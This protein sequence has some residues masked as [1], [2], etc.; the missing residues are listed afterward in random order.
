[1]PEAEKKRDLFCQ[2]EEWIYKN[3]SHSTS[4][5]FELGSSFLQGKGLLPAELS[6]QPLG[7]S[8]RF[9]FLVWSQ[10]A[11][12]GRGGWGMTQGNLENIRSWMLSPTGVCGTLSALT[13]WQQLPR[14][15]LSH[16][17]FFFFK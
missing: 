8:I 6:P 7:L 3:I 14:S 11:K 9:H 2:R 5:R 1:M 16:H 10:C 15:R 13:G 17:L 12:P 4:C